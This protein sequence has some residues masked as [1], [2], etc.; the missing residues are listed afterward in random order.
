MS[1]G[2]QVSAGDQV[3]GLDRR[4][5]TRLWAAARKR[6]ENNGLRLTASPLKLKDLDAG[7]TEALC[8][9]L[10][11]KRPNGTEM[12]VDVRLLDRVLTNSPTGLGLVDT[13]EVLSG[14]VRDRAAERLAKNLARAELSMLAHGHPVS[15]DP[16]I[17]AWFNSV[18]K[19]GRLSRLDE[20]PTE[21]LEG[22]L[23]A[24]G[25]LLANGESLSEPPLP[26]SMIAAVQLGDAHALDPDSAVGALLADA[27]C[28][29]AE[30]SDAR[31]AW[32]NVG[33]QVDQV[34]TSALALNLPGEAG[35]ICATASASGQPVRITWRMLEQGFGL[36]LDVVRSEHTRIRIC[37][38]PGV[39]SVAA[40]RLGPNCA[41]LICTEGMPASVTSD[42]LAGAAAAGADLT[43]H[44]DF[45]FGGVAIMHHVINRFGATPW[46][47]GAASY[48]R[49]MEG[50]TTALAHTIGP[51]DWD[52]A[53]SGAMNEQRRA[54]HEEALVFD[55][56]DDLRHR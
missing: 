48:L 42:L 6:L 51:T 46:R 13:L 38:N 22:V 12:N 36:D 32:A 28:H 9:L 26:L 27:V 23:D 43:V 40:D 39:L 49:A 8:A 31:R 17:Q 19:R 14:P 5:L 24:L 4:E 54:V 55:L 25:W 30:T 15:D 20:E 2:D 34:S 1:G 44:A 18:R 11:R 37:E 53:L 33:V 21:V 35:S 52:D 29:V 56:L 7:E 45:D 16:R 47:M 41:P 10:G 3:N 50:P